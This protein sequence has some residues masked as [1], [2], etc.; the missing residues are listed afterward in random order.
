M[1]RVLRDDATPSRTRRPRRVAET[2]EVRLDWTIAK[3]GPVREASS[4]VGLRVVCWLTPE[5]RHVHGIEKLTREIDVD[6][7]GFWPEPKRGKRKNLQWEPASVNTVQ[8]VEE[9]ASD[10]RTI[11]AGLPQSAE[12]EDGQA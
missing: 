7:K 10:M 6:G 5:G 2:D 8:L 3:K 1:T 9:L 12:G 4:N 11:L